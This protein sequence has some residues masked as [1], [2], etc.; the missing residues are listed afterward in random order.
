L[1]QRQTASL[2]FGSPSGANRLIGP[3]HQIRA[4]HLV[5]IAVQ[6]GTHAIDKKS[7]GRQCGYRNG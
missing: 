3:N 7:D 4:Q 5:R 2:G 1:R 6:A